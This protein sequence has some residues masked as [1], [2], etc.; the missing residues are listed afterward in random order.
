[1][2]I[3]TNDD[4]FDARGAAGRIADKLGVTARR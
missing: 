1:V 2:I 4:A 3:L